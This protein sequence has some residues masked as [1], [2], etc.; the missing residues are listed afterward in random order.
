MSRARVSLLAVALALAGVLSL[1]PAAPGAAAR[2]ADPVEKP[3]VA[4]PEP[5]ST[6][7]VPA[8]ARD[9]FVYTHDPD[10]APARPIRSLAPAV[11]LPPPP[12]LADSTPPAPPGPRLVGIV[13]QG[14]ALKAAISL[15]GEVMVVRVGE[16]AGV[17]T[18]LAIDEDEGVRLGDPTGAALTLAPPQE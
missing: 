15:D 12:S 18:V 14:G 2:P 13:R 5:R 6:P 7:A 17:Y 16:R 8:P 11:A 9:I 3:A 10:E 1:R 4:V